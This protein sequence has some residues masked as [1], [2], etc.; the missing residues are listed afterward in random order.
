[1]IYF[2][3]K[4]K[5]KSNPFGYRL[6]YGSAIDFE[7]FNTQGYSWVLNN[8]FFTTEDLALTYAADSGWTVLSSQTGFDAYYTS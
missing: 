4:Y 8:S 7:Y 1:M 3:V 2:W 6:I 5:H